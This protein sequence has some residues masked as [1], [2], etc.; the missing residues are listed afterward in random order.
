MRCFAAGLLALGLLFPIG[1]KGYAEPAGIEGAA[2][3]AVDAGNKF[4]P[5]SGDAVSGKDFVEHQGKRYGLCCPACEKPFL[6][7]PEKYIAKME[8]QESQ[9]AHQHGMHGMQGMHGAG[10]GDDQPSGLS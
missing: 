3:Q 5:V 8:K 2:K 10:A 1:M 4:C 6:A 7:D 9:Q